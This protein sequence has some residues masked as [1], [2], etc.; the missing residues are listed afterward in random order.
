MRRSILRD[1]P[2]FTIGKILVLGCVAVMIL[3]VAAVVGRTIIRPDSGPLVDVFAL[4]DAGQER[5][6]AAWWTAALLVAASCAAAMVG[7][8]AVTGSARS[9]EIVAW[10]V[11]AV[12]FAL[13]SLDEVVSLHERGARWTAAAIDADSALI[14]LGWLL[15]ASAIL[16]LS[17]A[18]LVP[19]FRA[20]P[21]RPRTFVFAGLAVSIGGAM[22]L[23]FLDV[24]LINAGAELRWRYIAMALEE[25]AEMAGILIVLAGIS[26]AVRMAPADGNLMF[27]YLRAD[28]VRHLTE[29]TETRPDNRS[30]STN[31]G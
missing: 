16:V 22:G 28:G 24:A 4:L 29:A 19:T 13:L 25:A 5:T 6:L 7:Q 17:L 10:R 9:R 2:R 1:D 15:P 8:L 18:V 31:A 20:L 11:L 26:M 23:E 3:H 27:S 21:R 14:Q 30:V 12:I